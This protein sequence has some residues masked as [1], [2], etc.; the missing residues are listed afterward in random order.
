MFNGNVGDTIQEEANVLGSAQN[1]KD[2][3]TGQEGDQGNDRNNISALVD[4]IPLL[5]TEV[6]KTVELASYPCFSDSKYRGL[7]HASC[8]HQNKEE[9]NK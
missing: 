8:G 4:N 1:E 6:Q 2:L 5:N 7:Q 9:A 3:I